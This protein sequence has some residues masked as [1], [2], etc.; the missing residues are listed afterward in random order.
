MG[1]NS[2][3]LIR[4]L[5]EERG[6]NQSDLAD[7]SGV[8]QGTISKIERGQI[9]PTLSQLAKIAEALGVTT[10]ELRGESDGGGASPGADGAAAKKDK[11]LLVFRPEDRLKGLDEVGAMNLY[12]DRAS[13]LGAFLTVWNSAR[14]IRI[15]G[16][17]I[18]GFWRAVGIRA[19][20]LLRLKLEESNQVKIQIILTH[21]TFAILREDQENVPHGYIIEQIRATEEFLQK[22]KGSTKEGQSLEWRYFKGTPTCFLVMA[23]EYMLL[24][25]YPYMNP[26]Y[27]NFSLIVKKTERRLFD[28]YSRYEQYHFLEPWQNSKLCLESPGVDEAMKIVELIEKTPDKDE[29]RRLLIESLAQSRDTSGRTPRR[30]KG[31]DKTD[32]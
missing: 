14:L 1:G 28:I 22:L 6:L 13:A 8:P 11:D 18:E 3:D 19:A 31:S 10:N 16:S 27:F 15:V 4:K 2:S 30:T 20:D 21:A 12:R 24:N 23:D 29:S 9:Q 25:P 7:Q 17:T 5:R 32:G 26:G